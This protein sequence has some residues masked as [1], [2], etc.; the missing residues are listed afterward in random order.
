METKDSAAPTPVLLFKALAN[1]KRLKIVR[2]LASCSYATNKVICKNTQIDQPQVS[3][4][5]K[6]LLKA[7]MVT[8]E[9]V[10]T[11]KIFQLNRSVWHTVEHL[12]G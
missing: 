7:N 3:D 11:Q 5:L 4:V 1:P 2:Y 12:L 9:K 8:Q 6:R 10:G